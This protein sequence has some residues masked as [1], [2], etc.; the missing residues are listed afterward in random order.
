MQQKSHRWLVSPRFDL[1]AFVVPGALALVLA[2]MIGLQLEP[3]EDDSLA[4]WIIGV[5][6]VDVAHVW[7][8]LY[9]TY[10]DADARAHHRQLLQWTPV[11]VF[12][13][14]F[15]AHAVSP[16]LFWGALAY[17]AVFHFIKQQDGFVALYLR[18]GD[19]TG[20][21]AARD[22]ALAKLAIWAGTAGPVIWWHTQLPRRFT[23]FIADDFI[24]GLPAI[25]G[26]V[27]VWAQAPILLVFLVRRAQLA[28]RKIGHPMVPLL[29]ALTAASWNLG[30]VWFNDGRVFTITNVFIHGLPYLA[31]VWI[32]GGRDLVAKRLPSSAKLGLTVAAFYGLLVVLA[33]AEE[34]L[35]DRLVWH[36]HPSLFG[37]GGLE[38]GEFGLA[39]S[40]ALLSVPQATHY[41]LD[42][43]IWR[44]GPHNPRLA[45][46]LGL[47]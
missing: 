1:G 11:L 24:P 16:R 10:L 47:T 7:A 40:V 32:A 43:Y 22:R 41:V 35:W 29:V 21:A 19:E 13:L 17:V 8:S 25:I 23:W 18:A 27:A 9:R 33:L 42:R 45:E 12:L 39:L 20:P 2:L 31:L 5:V 15:M 34:A 14:A 46:Q 26:T 30:I 44:V 36:D 6:L 37:H 4:L 38:L 28:K 3:A